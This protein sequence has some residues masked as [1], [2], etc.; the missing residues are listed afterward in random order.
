M[1]WKT[2]ACVCDALD[3]RVCVRV[4]EKTLAQVPP[5]KVQAK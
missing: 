5:Q 1:S 3:K 2:I 4:W